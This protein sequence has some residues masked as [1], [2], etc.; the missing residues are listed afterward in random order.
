[1]QAHE[2][3]SRAKRGFTASLVRQLIVQSTG[4]IT[5][6]VLARYLAPKDFGVFGLVSMIVQFFSFFAT[7]GLG[8]AVIRSKEEP[9]AVDQNSVFTCELIVASAACLLLVGV[10]LF[11]PRINSKFSADNMALVWALAFSAW[12]TVFRLL[13]SVSL[14]RQLEFSKIALVETVENLAF[15][16]IAIFMAVRH[17]G[18]WA[19]VAAT[20]TRSI[21]GAAFLNFLAPVRLQ[22]TLASPRLK[23]MLAVG[24]GFQAPNLIFFLKDLVMPGFIA[25]TLGATYLGYFIWVRDFA[26]KFSTFSGLFAKIAFP[27][28]A[29]LSA[30]GEDLARSVK[31]STLLLGIVYW[32][33]PFALAATSSFY[34][35]YIFSDKWF[36]AQPLLII[37]VPT[38][39]FQIVT[40]PWYALSQTKS[41]WHWPLKVAVC[42]ATWDV[43]AGVILIKLFGLAGCGIAVFFSS[44]L[45]AYLY[46]T[47]MRRILPES[48][49]DALVPWK[50][51]L[52]LNPIIAT[53]C[54]FLVSYTTANLLAC[55]AVTAFTCI[56]F[57]STNW[58]LFPDD[59]AMLGK[60]VSH[61]RPEPR[62]A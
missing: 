53:G 46:Y 40:N 9:S 23:S 57:A 27:T 16:A 58:L 3:A 60:I 4:I 55:L 21:A 17:T 2:V 54:F 44:G 56:V 19:L 51:K 39:L 31:Q 34:I 1:M 42:I 35:H 50:A 5:S 33:L 20:M 25:A 10:S 59:R 6:I 18:A 48:Y 49:R 7:T 47:Q 29:K 13:P 30:V 38:M 22:L 8:T 14:E 24:L 62:T 15:N 36:P 61:F 45:Y 52:L 26:A 43:C 37:Y 12:L 11:L 32:P 41:H 28:M